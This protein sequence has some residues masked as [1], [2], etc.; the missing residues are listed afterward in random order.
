[1][2]LH[3][4]E[5]E[6]KRAHD[7]G[8]ARHTADH[9]R[10]VWAITLV[11]S[12]YSSMHTRGMHEQSM[13]HIFLKKN[14]PRCYIKSPTAQEAF[15]PIPGL[16]SCTGVTGRWGLICITIHRQLHEGNLVG[17]LAHML[18][19]V[20]LTLLLKYIYVA[21]YLP[22]PTLTHANVHVLYCDCVHLYCTCTIL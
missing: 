21:Y 2:Y 13:N 17:H 22:S 3:R 9:K 15:R 11:Y 16:I 1:M 6:Q 10:C 5:R 20:S 8:A 7:G 12:A 14:R 18:Y 19:T 4:Q